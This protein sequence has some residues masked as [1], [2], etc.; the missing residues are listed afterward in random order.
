ML[1]FLGIMALISLLSAC[2]TWGKHESARCHELK[3]RIVYNG[4]PYDRSNFNSPSNQPME[5]TR[6]S[7]E[8]ASVNREFREEG[9]R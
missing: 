3:S 8:M 9:C 2:S 6:A 4:T 7:A 5:E 1:R